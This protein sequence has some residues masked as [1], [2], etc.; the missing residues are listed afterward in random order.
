MASQKSNITEISTK[1]A[2]N[3]KTMPR[4]LSRTAER[5]WYVN[6]Q[7][8]NGLEKYYP[9]TAKE[10]DQICDKLNTVYEDGIFD[11]LEYD[12]ETHRILVQVSQLTFCQFMLESPDSYGSI[13]SALEDMD[14][15]SAKFYFV[16]T[17]NPVIFSSG[18]DQPDPAD[19]GDEGQL[20]NFLH[21]LRG[22]YE[23]KQRLRLMDELGRIA[24]FRQEDLALVEIPLEVLNPQY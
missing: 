5:K 7:L 20:N 1:A 21:Y 8:C 23:K 22:G 9:I 13:E 4:E 6:Y 10:K 17:P 19:E 11:F 24:F 18:P 16:N 3:G 2:S 15:F 14:F 12:T